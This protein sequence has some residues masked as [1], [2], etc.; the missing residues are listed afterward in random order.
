MKW[1]R[2][3]V[4]KSA[5]VSTEDYFVPV[6][7]REICPADKISPAEPGAGLESGD[8]RRRELVQQKEAERSAVFEEGRLAGKHAA[9][10]EFKAAL[11]FL[12]QAAS[13]VD[14]DLARFLERLEGRV[15]VLALAIVR[16]I[17]GQ[18]SDDRA[19]LIRQSIRKV[20]A[21]HREPGDILTI[22]LHP[23]DHHLLAPAQEVSPKNLK[24]VSDAGIDRGGCV[25]ETKFGIVNAQVEAQ[26][27]EIEREL[28]LRAEEVNGDKAET[29]V[30][31]T[32][33]VRGEG[34]VV[35]MVGMVIESR[36]PNVTAGEHCEVLSA[37]RASSTP[38]EVIGFRKNRVLLMPLAEC[39]GVGPG[40]L[41]V[42][43]GT[44]FITKAGPQ[45]LGRVING[46]GQPIDGRG[47]LGGEERVSIHAQPNN[48]MERRAIKE[49]LYTGVRAIDGLIT[50]GKGV[51]MGIFAGSGVGKSV[52]LGMMG[53]NTLADINVIALIG[54]RGREV[55][56]FVENDLGPEGL[57]R[58]VVVAVTSDESPI[59]R[60]HGA[61]LAA[62]LAEYFA[63]QGKDVLFMMDSVT[64]FAMAC[65]EVGLAAGEPPA[66]KGYPPSTFAALPRLLERSGIFGERGSITGFYT[67]LVEGDDLDE[68]VADHVRSILDGHV[69]LSRALSAQNHFPAI[70]VLGSVSRLMRQVSTPEQI[71][72]SGQL[73]EYLATMAEA[74][75]LVNIGA[76]AKGS[77]PKIDRAIGCIDA[78]RGFLRQRLDEK[79]NPAEM[80]AQME[81]ILQN[82]PAAG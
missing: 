64:R 78:I 2:F 5:R 65:R 77:N 37:D 15:A 57:K 55:K 50:C 75:D 18:V 61:K 4:I 69:V 8:I 21:K 10:V 28:K 16:K 19:D 56:E 49:P 34:H 35:N 26:L 67:V 70:D 58:S 76:Y 68:P 73:R 14:Q 60:I 52:L 1:S 3:K 81:K 41:V 47:V 62:S 48:P 42:A 39:H 32:T 31:E 74:Q 71:K 53:R 24:F 66:T 20:L 25:L 33:E 44:Q 54:E 27:E 63:R 51:R 12:T 40:H 29:V 17:L 36:G 23:E 72:L 38:A 59:L 9:E 7:T 13:R 46:L 45:L 82:A 22:R 30:N 80:W 6:Y 11:E 43:R 79:I